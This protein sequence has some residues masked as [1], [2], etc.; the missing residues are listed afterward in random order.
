MTFEAAAMKGGAIGGPATRLLGPDLARGS[1]LLVIA[2]AHAPAHLSST[3]SMG[4]HRGL[5]QVTDVV[6][7]LLVEGRGYPVFAA[8][9]GYGVIQ[10][11]RRWP[12]EEG[13]GAALAML[14]RRG[15][16]LVVF[17]AVHAAL[18]WSGDILGA[19]GV[20]LL[21]G[22][23]L[24][25]GGGDRTLAAVAALSCV[26]VG[27][28]GASMAAVRSSSPD[29][30]L[31]AWG[32]V[33]QRLAEWAPSL[34]LQPLGLLGAALIGVLAA[35]RRVLEEPQRHSRLLF[36]VAVGGLG[37]AV[38]GGIPRTL[39]DQGVVQATS[40]MTAAA[41]GLHSITGYGGIGYAACAALAA[42]ALSSSG[43][44][45]RAVAACGQ[46]SL[47]S[48]LGQSVLFTA[49]MSP[50]LG[51]LGDRLGSAGAAAV[52]VVVWGST[53]AAAELMRRR[54]IRGPAESLL[55]RLVGRPQRQRRR[56]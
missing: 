35:R 15:A 50:S 17:G 22:A 9:F 34:V 24:M 12:V 30:A 40:T 2:A 54:G 42:T 26:V 19:Y 21:G 39:I 56:T 41:G 51:R 14:R 23:S 13:S 48:Y 5:D 11:V 46:R 16:W 25:V 33:G 20:L 4:T 36:G 49:I 52:A 32:A 7:V 53:V 29:A 45:T 44:I 28:G 55:R 37:A 38:V 6:S 1:M 31:P 3:P 47:T 18:L 10:V 8:L 27:L 43:R